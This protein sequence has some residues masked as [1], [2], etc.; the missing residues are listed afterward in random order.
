MPILDPLEQVRFE[1]FIGQLCQ[2]GPRPVGEF[3]LEFAG[4]GGMSALLALADTYKHLTPELATAVG[5]DRFPPQSLR[6]V[7]R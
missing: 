3:I 6:L 4:P 7:P 5:A 2:S 1:R